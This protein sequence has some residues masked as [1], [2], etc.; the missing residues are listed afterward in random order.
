MIFYIKSSDYRV[1]NDP[2]IEYVLNDTE[3]RGRKGIAKIEII[4]KLQALFKGAILRRRMKLMRYIKKL[5]DKVIEMKSQTEQAVCQGL[6]ERGA[7]QWIRF[8]KDETA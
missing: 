7:Y 5:Q 2:I 6:N 3:I 1:T 4:E 8:D